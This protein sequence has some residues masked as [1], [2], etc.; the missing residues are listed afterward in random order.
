MLSRRKPVAAPEPEFEEFAFAWLLVEAL[1]E[2]GSPLE[3]GDWQDIVQTRNARHAKTTIKLIF[4]IV[5][6]L[7][8]LVVISGPT[9][10]KKP[11]GSL[12]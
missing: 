1:E 10:E 9:M 3:E 7:S 4:F 8:L 6:L 12:G 11:P 5:S 2:A